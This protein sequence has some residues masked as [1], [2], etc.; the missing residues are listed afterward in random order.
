MGKCSAVRLE[1]WYL[2]AHCSLLLLQIE[3]GP[4]SEVLKKHPAEFNSGSENERFERVLSG[5]HLIPAHV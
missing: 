3:G 4:P 2:R 5:R 1:L